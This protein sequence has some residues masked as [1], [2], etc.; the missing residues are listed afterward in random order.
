VHQKF[1]QRKHALIELCFRVLVSAALPGHGIIEV[2]FSRTGA[3][4]MCDEEEKNS[5]GGKA[6]I[7]THSRDNMYMLIPPFSPYLNPRPGHNIALSIIRLDREQNIMFLEVQFWKSPGKQN[8]TCSVSSAFSNLNM[9]MC[10]IVEGKDRGRDVFIPE[11]EARVETIG[12]VEKHEQNLDRFG[13]CC[14]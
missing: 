12:M 3:I 10:D 9:C 5:R 13:D 6:S 4:W 11:G 14:V 1:W 2:E 8:K 7:Y